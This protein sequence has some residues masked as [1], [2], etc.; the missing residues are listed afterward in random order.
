MYRLKKTD[1]F[2][3]CTH[4]KL[5]QTVKLGNFTFAS[6]LFSRDSPPVRISTRA[7]LVVPQPVLLRCGRHS[8]AESHSAKRAYARSLQHFL[9]PLAKHNQQ[10]HDSQ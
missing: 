4:L 8:P 6:T 2:S 1:A 5:L 10:R 3:H 9:S 7:A